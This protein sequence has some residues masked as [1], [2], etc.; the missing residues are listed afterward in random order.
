MVWLSPWNYTKVLFILVRYLPMI[1]IYFLLNV[2]LLPDVSQKSCEVTLPI[3]TWLLNAGII[4]A[5]AILAIRTWAVWRKDKRIGLLLTALL[6]CGVILSS[7]CTNRFTHSLNFVPPLYPGYRG[8]FSSDAGTS[9]FETFIILALMD[10][11][12]LILMLISAF[13]A[14][15][16]GDRGELTNVI[17]KDAIV[18]YAYLMLCSIVSVIVTELYPTSLATMLSPLQGAFHSI[19]TC[20]IIFNIRR[21]ARRD[22]VADTSVGLHSDYI[23]MG[24]RRLQFARQSYLSD[25]ND[26]PDTQSV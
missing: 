14:Y 13:R 7:I 21:V 26:N 24:V 6:T 8:C 25:T 4:S 18:F 12:V 2:Q 17:H 19:F 1:N 23:E 20:R 22:I 9:L 16:S 11:V 15:R 3:A 10:G 5:E